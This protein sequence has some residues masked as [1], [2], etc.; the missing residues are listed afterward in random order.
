MIILVSLIIN[1]LCLSQT[2]LLHFIMTIG[3]NESIHIF[4]ESNSDSS[5]PMDK[6]LDRSEPKNQ[7]ASWK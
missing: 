1:F 2:W 3:N 5:K 4:P 7:I 6:K